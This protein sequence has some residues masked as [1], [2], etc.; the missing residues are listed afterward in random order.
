MKITKQRLREIIKEES[1]ALGSWPPG[2]QQ[3]SGLKKAEEALEQSIRMLLQILGP[4]PVV[5][6]L[7][8]QIKHI[9]NS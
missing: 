2:G 7:E 5:R 9:R 8:A 6:E 1:S 4:D 3:G